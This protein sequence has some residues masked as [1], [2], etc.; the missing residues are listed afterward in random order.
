[1]QEQNKNNAIFLG[2]II[3]AALVVFFTVVM[4][5]YVGKAGLW[6]VIL[7]LVAEAYGVYAF[8]RKIWNYK[9]DKEEK[10]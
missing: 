10:K 4:L 9:P 1:M 2:G 8:V 3:L 7:P 6:A 5:S